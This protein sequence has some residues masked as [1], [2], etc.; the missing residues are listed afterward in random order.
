MLASGR[1]VSS[2]MMCVAWLYVN[3]TGPPGALIAMFAPP[4][5]RPAP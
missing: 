4:L 2:L 1:G 5:T 3:V